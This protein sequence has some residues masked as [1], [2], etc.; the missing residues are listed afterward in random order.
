[1]RRRGGGDSEKG[2]VIQTNLQYRQ[3]SS[4]SEDKPWSDR[5]CGKPREEIVLAARSEKN[6]TRAEK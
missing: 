2:G 4:Y 5:N 6:P 3:R 1:M